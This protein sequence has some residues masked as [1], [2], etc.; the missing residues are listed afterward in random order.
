MGL[1]G[2]G[3]LVANTGTGAYII[4]LSA[5]PIHDPQ[6]RLF[7][8]ISA[9]PGRY[10]AEAAIPAAGVVYRWFSDRFY[11]PSG[12]GAGEAADRFAEINKEVEASP[13]GANGVI[14]LPYFKG[15][16]A[17]RWDPSAKGMFWGLG[18]STSRGDM[19]RAVLEGIAAEMADDLDLVEEFAG[20]KDR[21][22]AAGGLTRFPEFCRILADIFGRTV[23]GASDSEATSRGAWISAACRLGMYPDLATAF[24]A[25]ATAATAATAARAPKGAPAGEVVPTYPADPERGAVYLNLR[26]KRERLYRAVAEAGL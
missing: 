20:K 22:F 15:A 25:A 13:P 24:A 18:L 10:V 2:E 23:I 8:N 14:L 21:I 9:I 12:S 5:R 19:A 4:G 3:D 6:Q 7:C 11:A 17:P 16:G 26:K 1:L